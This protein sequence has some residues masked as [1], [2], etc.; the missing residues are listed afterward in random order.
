MLASEALVVGERKEE[1]RRNDQIL[2][3]V[4]HGLE[5]LPT[6]EP[7]RDGAHTSGEAGTEQQPG[8]AEGVEEPPELQP[9]AAF[10]ISVRAHLLL[11]RQSVQVSTRLGGDVEGAGARCR[12]LA[13]LYL[14][15][16]DAD[17]T[18]RCRD[19]YRKQEYELHRLH[20]PVR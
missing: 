12:H 17:D 14:T 7:L 1:E 6:A 19:R 10:E 3:D 16:C 18:H 13:W 15:A 4:D 20:L 5:R 9:I 11:G 8:D 2:H